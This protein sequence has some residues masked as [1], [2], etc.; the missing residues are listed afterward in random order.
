[1]QFNKTDWADSSNKKSCL[2]SSA[3]LHN[4][5]ILLF[6]AA[7]LD[8]LSRF[9]ADSILVIKPAE[10]IFHSF[11]LVCFLPAQ[12]PELACQRV[13]QCQSSMK[14]QEYIAGS[15]KNNTFTR[16]KTLEKLSHLLTQLPHRHSA[17][18]QEQPEVYQC[19]SYLEH[20]SSQTSVFLELISSS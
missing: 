14:W 12:W 18:N 8:L 1:M 10:K 20:A 5:M 17:H 9:F 13:R 19:W 3:L 2:L 16:K 6:S 7:A 15:K 11:C 4:C